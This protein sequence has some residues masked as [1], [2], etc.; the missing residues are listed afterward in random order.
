LNGLQGLSI[1]AFHLSKDAG[2]FNSNSY[3][4][5]LIPNPSVVTIDAGNVTATMSVAGVNV[6][7]MTLPDLSLQPG[8]NSYP[9]Y[10]TTNQTQVAALLKQP[11]YSCGKLPL[12]VQADASTYEGQRIEYLT[13]ALQSATLKVNLDVAPTLNEA[14]FGFLLGDACSK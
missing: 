6:A 10:A 12:D 14:G 4:T 5:L 3:G 2:A 1:S 7:N 9:F 13:V 8:D 11:E